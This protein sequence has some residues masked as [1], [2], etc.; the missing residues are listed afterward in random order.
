MGHGTRP[1]GFGS[2]IRTFEPDNTETTMYIRGGWK[3]FHS[4][5]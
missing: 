2:N 1:G 3:A 4:P 5:T